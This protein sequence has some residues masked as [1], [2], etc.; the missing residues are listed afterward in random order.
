MK[1]NQYK[2]NKIVYGRQDLQKF[3]SI[4]G[5][6]VPFSYVEAYK[7][8]RTNLE[9][10]ASANG[11]KSILVTSAIPNESKSTTAIN[12]AIALAESK[13]KVIVVECDLR[14]PVFRKY[15]KIGGKPKGLSSIL[16]ADAAPRDCVIALEDLGISVI[17]AGII[18]PNPSEL[19]NTNLMKSLIELLKQYYDYV[20]LDAPPVTVVTDAVV[21][22]KMVDGVL[23]VVRSKLAL[24]KTVR[25]AK[26]RL[27]SVNARILG[28]VLT[29][30]DTGQLSR[31]SGYSYSDYEYGYVQTKK[32]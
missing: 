32:K 18:P 26:R 19:L 7:I 23:L 21:V 10:T 25:L 3:H 29:R 4:K 14:K 12:L 9:F 2:K 6:D 13:H 20:I 11:A 5:K 16:V 22:S 8:L 27:E 1:L 28:T 17:H 15:L 30:Y 24:T 31:R